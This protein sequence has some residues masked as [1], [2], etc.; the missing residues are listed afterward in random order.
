MITELRSQLDATAGRLLSPQELPDIVEWLE[1][2]VKLTDKDSDYRGPFKT[3]NCPDIREILRSGVSPDVESTVIVGPTQCFKTTILMGID[4]YTVAIDHGPVGHV[5]P[6]EALARAFSTR[7]FQPTVQSSRAL[8][9]LRPEN[10]DHFKTLELGFKTCTLRFAGSNSPTNVASFAYRRVI[11]DEV[12]KFPQSLK[13]EAGTLDL[14]MQR[15]GQFTHHNIILASTPTVASGTIW[16]EALRGDCRR[17]YVPC[18]RCTRL[19]TWAFGGLRWDEKAKHANGSWDMDRVA[20]S[21]HYQCPH[22][23]NEIHEHERRDMLHAGQWIPDEKEIADQRRADFQLVA[24]PRRRSYFRS[25]F[26]VLHPNRTFARI[27]EKHLQAGKDPSKRQNFTNSELGEVFEDAGETVEWE[28][29]MKRA[30]NYLTEPEDGSPPVL[31]EGALVLVAGVDKQA[32]PARLECEIVGFGA[33]FESWGVQYAI[34]EKTTTW[35]EAWERLDRL[36]LTPWLHPHGFTLAPMAVCVDT[37]H[38]PEDVYDY[39]RRCY[40]RKVYAVKGSSEGY[41]QPLVSRPHKSGVKQVT[42]YMVGGTTAKE[43]LFSRMR[44]VD[45]GPGRMHYPVEPKRGY[46]AEYF[47]QLTAERCV[48]RWSAGRKVKKFVR[49]GG[50]PNEALDI[51]CYAR[52]ALHLLNPNFAKLK[53]KMAKAIDEV[54]AAPSEPEHVE[55]PKAPV[56]S[57]RLRPAPVV[58]RGSGNL[59]GHLAPQVPRGGTFATTW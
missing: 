42:L 50:R 7:R 45:D 37:G 49:I 8:A 6:T 29:L 53:E 19:F 26:N 24:D 15:V 10:P 16:I 32:N 41:G 39:V 40:P 5:M 51:R 1:G 4:C 34:I 21:A 56:N 12:D 25:C 43:E 23:Q 17:Y 44:I 36:L 27:A 38:E 18:P 2:N 9:S 58:Q 28:V 14:M 13:H 11:G 46:D 3:D 55:Q 31:P 57:Y 54:S 20:K 33:D 52:A 47:R 30:E 35:R 48:E 59:L 22:C